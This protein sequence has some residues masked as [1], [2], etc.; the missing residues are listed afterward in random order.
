MLRESR[1]L[2]HLP[3]E[4]TQDIEHQ[5]GSL[6]LATDINRQ[7]EFL[8]RL[9]AHLD[10]QNLSLE[11]AGHRHFMLQIA[12]KCADICNPCRIWD[13]SK[14]WSERVCEEFYRQGDLEKKFEL[15]IS[16]LCNQQKDTIPSIQIGFMTYIAEPLFDEWV[17]FTGG[18]RLS[19]N[20]LS[21][22][23]TNKAI[24]RDLLH[25]QRAQNNDHLNQGTE[26]KGDQTLKEGGAP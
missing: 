8:C 1:L 25:K 24:W 23:R 10:N 17:R 2:A 26:K 3:K 11:D 9:K 18:T 12:L 14:L 7:N 16:P 20:M 5:L 6:I 13:L 15:E 21:H 4:M 19:E 22:L